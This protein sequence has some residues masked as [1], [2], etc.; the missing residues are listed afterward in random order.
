MESNPKLDLCENCF[1]YRR[2]HIEEGDK[3]W[4][5]LPIGKCIFS[6][7]KCESFKDTKTFAEKT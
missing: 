4:V 2:C 6:L 3:S 1:H 5:V 7:C